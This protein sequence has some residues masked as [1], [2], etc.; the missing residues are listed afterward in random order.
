MRFKNNKYRNI[1]LF[2]DF[3][4][5]GLSYLLKYGSTKVYASYL[6]CKELNLNIFDVDLENFLLK[7][8]IPI[9]NQTWTKE[10]VNYM[11]YFHNGSGFDFHFLLPSLYSH[12]AKK[13]ISVFWFKNKDIYFIKIKVVKKNK[14]IAY[15]TFACSYLIFRTSIAKMGKSLGKE[16]IDNYDYDMIDIF[17]TNQDFY[18]HDNGLSYKYLK[19]DVE[20][21]EEFFYTDKGVH[22]D[23][24]RLTNG[25]TAMEFLYLINPELKDQKMWLTK[26]NNPLYTI[27]LWN[28]LKSSHVGGFCYVNPKYQLKK[29]H[30]VSVYDFNSLYAAVMKFKK[31][32]YGYPSFYKKIGYDYE[33]YYIDIVEAKTDKTPFFADKDRI[34]DYIKFKEKYLQ[35][36]HKEKNNFINVEDYADEK[37]TQK[38]SNQSFLMDKY[39]LEYFEKNYKGTW[40]KKFYCSFKEKNGMFD[41]YI[42]HWET[43]KIN[44]EKAG[45]MVGRQFAKEQAI[46]PNGKFG[47]TIYN[48][49]TDMVEVDKLD[50]HLEML[51]KKYPKFIFKYYKT[52]K[53]EYIIQYFKDDN[54]EYTRASLKRLGHLYHYSLFIEINTRPNYLPIAISILS[55]ARRMLF[56]QINLHQDSF[57][58]ADTDSVHLLNDKV[59]D[60][61]IDPYIFGYLKYEGTFENAVYRRPKHYLHT[62]LLDINGKVIDKDF[63]ELKGGGFNVAYFNKTKEISV[64]DYLQEEF[65]VKGGKRVKIN[66]EKGIVLAEVDYVFKLPLFYYQNKKKEKQNDTSKLLS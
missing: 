40:T 48:K 16:K 21:L 15:I 3:E 8:F 49:K 4:T 38:L 35:Q 12:F 64:N 25:S 39:Q 31:L 52:P 19:R 46:L 54:K 42:K 27:D 57:V 18:N 26:K 62:G 20:I 9:K 37:Y 45:N 23:F 14:V 50:E 51:N 1:Y 24:F 41:D 55:Q 36:K 10:K 6:K 47:Q 66:T 22:Y 58:Y 5:Y 59:D 28:D 44:F 13:N 43:L 56:E 60:K 30:N 65:K 29:L 63:Y 17:K 11:I 53:G 33:F 61:Y 32:P 7:L 2:G 34:N